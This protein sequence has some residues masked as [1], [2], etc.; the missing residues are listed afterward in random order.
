MKILLAYYLSIPSKLFW[1]PQSGIVVN[2]L[3]HL[4]KSGPSGALR[5]ILPI[6][7]PYLSSAYQ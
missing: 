6:G 1:Q 4:T 7:A 2:S 3:W 5:Y